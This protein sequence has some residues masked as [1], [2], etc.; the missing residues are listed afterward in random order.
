M[1]TGKII[2]RA[3]LVELRSRWEALNVRIVFTNGVFDILHRGH[4]EY[5]EKAGALGDVLIL[6]VN[7]DASAHRLKGKGRPVVGQQDR[8]AVLAALEAVDYVC[9][10]D[11][12]TP[13]ELI[14]ALQPHVLVKGGDYRIEDIVGRD[15]VEKRGGEV[16]TV[17]L[18]PGQSTTGV[19]ERIVELVKKGILG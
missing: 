4:V 5:L 10:F 18:T 2:T 19:I 15:T 12:D 9:L 3:E 17:S 7:S 13:A 14:A 1:D 16:V 8:A 6:G 11:E